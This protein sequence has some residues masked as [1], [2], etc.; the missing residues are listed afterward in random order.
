MSRKAFSRAEETIELK[1]YVKSTNSER[2]ITIKEII[3]EIEMLILDQY[4]IKKPKRPYG[5]F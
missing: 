4:K 2:N 3:T 1:R 5:I